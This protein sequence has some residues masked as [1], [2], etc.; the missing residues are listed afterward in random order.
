MEVSS[1]LIPTELA[2]RRIR[3][4]EKKDGRI[5]V[6]TGDALRHD[7]FAL[8]LQREFGKRVVAWFQVVAGPAPADDPAPSSLPS[9]VYPRIRKL[10]AKPS[11]LLGVPKYLAG[12][13]RERSR[14]APSQQSVEQRLFGEELRALRAGAHLQPMPVNDPNLPAL[15]EQV[16]EL[17]PYLILT[18]GGAIYR[19]P[20]LET[21][22]G[23]A[24]NQHAGWSP[25]YKGSETVVWALY[26]RD[27]DRV[28]NTVHV[29]TSG[30][31]AGPIVRRSTACLTP[32]D[33][34]QS[35]FARVVALGTELMCE[36]VAEILRSEELTVYDQPGERGLTYLSAD[37]EPYVT[38][39]VDRDIRNG[40][41]PRELQRLREF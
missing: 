1:P 40:L 31:D 11:T 38:D 22:R 26:H 2:P 3:L 36:V 29:L 12:Y 6:F 4:P 16:R 7:R 34:R 28:G 20:L 27:L 41:L 21:A 8:R 39:A 19:R 30:L 18:L 15:V 24:L 14:P 33:D 17:D 5:V 37:L 10:I 25:D 35:C 23:L 32:A 13:L 9:R